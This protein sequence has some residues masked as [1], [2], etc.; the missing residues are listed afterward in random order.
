[1]NFI[2]V[3]MTNNIFILKTCFMYKMTCPAF[4]LLLLKVVT[5][6][7]QTLVSGEITEI[8]L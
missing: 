5:V 8:R 6:T 4:A 1:M 3:E 2:K 7:I